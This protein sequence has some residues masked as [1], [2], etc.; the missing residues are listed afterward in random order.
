MIMK[1]DGTR[2]SS[3]Y[4]PLLVMPAAF[5]LG[6]TMWLLVPAQ[7][8]AQ[9]SEDEAAIRTLLREAAE[10]EITRDDAVFD[11]IAAD[12]F[13]RNGANGEVWDKEHTRKFGKESVNWTIN[14]IETRDLNIRIYGEAAA[15]TALGIANGQDR[16]GHN[17]TVRNRCSFMLV[18]RAGRWQCVSV[19]QTRAV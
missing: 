8:V 9:T 7:E 4:W 2:R 3:R 14:S 12:E 11:R 13:V 16:A 5:L 10:N 6:F 15:V 19:Q 17:I 18:K 1:Q